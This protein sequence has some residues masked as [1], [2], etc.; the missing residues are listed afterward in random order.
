MTQIIDYYF[1]LCGEIFAL[2][3]SQWVLSIFFMISVIGLIVNLVNN[4]QGSGK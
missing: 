1:Q 3:K 2:I 4:A